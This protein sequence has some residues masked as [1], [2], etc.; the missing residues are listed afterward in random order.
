[1]ADSQVLLFSTDPFLGT[2]LKAIGRGSRTVVRYTLPSELSEWPKD[3]HYNVVLDVPRSHRKAAYESIR[4]HHQGRLVLVLGP[5]ED[6]S[7]LPHDR[8]RLTV[9]RPVDLGRLLNLLAEPKN[10]HEESAASPA[11]S[12]AKLPRRVADGPRQP[13][14]PLRPDQSGAPMG[15][16]PAAPPP[17][18][19]T[20][21]LR[22]TPKTQPSTEPQYPRDQ[23]E[24]PASV[25]HSGSPAPFA[26]ATPVPRPP[27][28]HGATSEEMAAADRNENGKP[29]AREP[30]S[31]GRAAAPPHRGPG[32]PVGG[33]WS[34]K[35]GGTADPSQVS[36]LTI[37]EIRPAVGV[38]RRPARGMLVGIGLILTTCLVALGA[39]FLLGL[40]DA[41]RDTKASA[42]AARAKLGKV[43]EAL[44]AGEVGTA[45]DASRGASLD[46]DTASAVLKRR[47]V[48]L[49]ARLPVLSGTVGDLKHLLAAGRSGTQAGDEA[50][51]LYGTFAS[52]QPLLLRDGRFDFKILAQATEHAQRLDAELTGAEQELKAVRGGLLDLGASDAKQAGL[53]QI[54]DL[55]ERTRWLSPLLGVLPRVLGQDGPQRYV[56]VLANPAESRPGGGAPVAAVRLTL[57]KGVVH[58]EERHGIVAEKLHHAMVTWTAAPA[59]PWRPGPMFRKFSD[60]N[61]SPHFPTSGQ[62]LLR[63]YRAASGQQVDS[64]ISVDPMSIRSLLAT[65]GPLRPRGWGEL[66]ADNIGPLTM[67]DA[68]ELWPDREVRLRQNELLV[69]AV[70]KRFLDGKEILAKARA[71]GTEARGHHLQI[72]FPTPAIQQV[73]QENH[74]DGAL[75]GASHDYLAVYT[76]NTNNSRVDFFQRRATKQIVRL[77]GDGSATV[78]REVS[79]ANPTPSSNRLRTGPKE[80][81]SSRFSEPILAVYLPPTAT[82]QSVAVDGRPIPTRQAIEAGRLFVRTQLHLIPDGSSTVTVVY[83]LPAAAERTEDG[84]RYEL[85]ADN[86]PLAVPP[87]LEV[88]VV[89]PAHMAATA[90]PGWE[91]G[92]RG[93]IFRRPFAASFATQLDIH[94]Q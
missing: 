55:R 15:Q 75:A 38:A 70:V 26:P 52:D 81:Y 48:R 92:A 31:A 24:P 35:P 91:V 37:P 72:Y 13:S 89:P 82:L 54:A 36:I 7:D 86:Q 10:P 42:R 51:K 43:S 8:A 90:S 16:E 85:V 12:T 18:K 53:E 50:V 19:P 84:L 87:A 21:S 83:H 58:L 60:A 33:E 64:I 25:E 30:R 3:E 63:A 32:R 5:G 23:S 79:V 66:T 6:D 80:G 93:A 88:T 34:S 9:N 77:N 4:L 76:R 61:S 71:L 2:A 20:T 78:T 29:A 65:T 62:E 17:P 1:M 14:R 68:F 28:D 57:D 40:H 44:N 74:L 46:L 39:W 56:I 22:A 94:R 49:A 41:A 47:P 11:V 27:I 73:V 67:H 59:D 69:D 45:A